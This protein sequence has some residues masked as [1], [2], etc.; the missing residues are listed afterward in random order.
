MLTQEMRLEVT[1]NN[2]ANVDTAG[3]RPDRAVVH[4]FNALL[5]SRLYDPID[6]PFP[7]MRRI[8][9]VPTIGQ[10]GTGSYVQ[11]IA[12][13]FRAQGP[14]QRTAR[15]LD[16]AID[17]TGFLA[18]QTPQGVRYTRAG[19]FTRGANDVVV[20]GDGQALLGQ[21][22]P[23][24]LPAGTDT[25]DVLIDP[26]GNVA[27][28]GQ[29]LDRLIVADVL[30]GAQKVGYTLVDATGGVTPVGPDSR[31]AQGVLE[32]SPVNAVREM[33]D[34]IQVQRQYEA[35]QKVVTAEDETLD[36]LL[37]NVTG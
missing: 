22:G 6:T 11:E 26:N 30:P 36:R 8:D 2:L 23:I 17:G 32:H 34:L 7:P 31:V 1:T 27:V 35:N 29:V 4:D 12:T 16:L 24:T 9:P 10:L 25:N 33:V 15:P 13:D 5:L 20:N 37:T 28:N 18:V 14:M 21:A 19:S 3:Y